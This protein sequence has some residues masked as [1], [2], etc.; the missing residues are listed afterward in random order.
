MVLPGLTLPSTVIDSET[1]DRVAELESIRPGFLAD[2]ITTFEEDSL[3]RLR[4]IDQALQAGDAEAL[5]KAA[6]TL[7]SSCGIVG[8]VRMWELCQWL[9]DRGRSESLDRAEEAAELLRSEFTAACQLLR[10]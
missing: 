2:I 8:A 4:L 10:R 9:E 6:H 3:L 1:Y 5:W 7:K